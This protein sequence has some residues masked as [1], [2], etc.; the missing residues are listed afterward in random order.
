VGGARCGM[1]PTGPSEPGRSVPRGPVAG[2]Y[3][4]LLSSPTGPTGLDLIPP[5]N[6]LSQDWTGAGPLQPLD[7][8][9][10]LSCR[11]YGAPPLQHV[12]RGFA[13]SSTGLWPGPSSGRTGAALSSRW[14]GASPLQPVNRGS[15][16][17]P[18][19]LWRWASPTVGL[20]LR[21]SNDLVERSTIEVCARK[22]LLGLSKTTACGS[23]WWPAPASGGEAGAA[24]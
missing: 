22:L 16:P 12:N 15:A 20:G 18:T 14:T 8:G 17:S 2:G 7:R 24:G 11:W 3:G 5:S 21:S 1:V 23:S 9:P 4:T 10:A 6:R 13:P 19:G